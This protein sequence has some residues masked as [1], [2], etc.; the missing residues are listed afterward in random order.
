MIIMIIIIIV[1][2][3]YVGS[4]LKVFKEKKATKMTALIFLSIDLL[5]LLETECMA[6]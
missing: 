5:R 2:R 6:R 1:I 3:C 4:P